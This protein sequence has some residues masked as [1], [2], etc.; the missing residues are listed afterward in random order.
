M[1]FDADG[2]HDDLVVALAIATWCADRGASFFEPNGLRAGVS[3]PRCLIGLDLAEPT[4]SHADSDRA[5]PGRLPL[6]SNEPTD[7][8]SSF[9]HRAFVQCAVKALTASSTSS[10]VMRIQVSPLAR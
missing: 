7:A 2:R 9:G 4:I 6:A 5:S 8:S 10:A 1:T 3:A